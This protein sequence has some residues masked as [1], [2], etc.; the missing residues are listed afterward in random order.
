VAYNSADHIGECIE[1]VLVERHEVTQ[2]VIVVDNA[3]KDDTAARVRA[4]FLEV[5]VAVLEPGQNLGFAAG[6]NYGARH[7][8][9]EFVLLLNPDTVIRN[10]AIDAIVSFARSSP[11]HGLYGGR[12]LRPDGALEP[13]SCWG[14]GGGNEL[15]LVHLTRHAGALWTR[16]KQPHSSR[17][18]RSYSHKLISTYVPHAP[19]GPWDTVAIHWPPPAVECNA[20]VPGGTRWRQVIVTGFRIDEARI[21]VCPIRRIPLHDPTRREDQ[22]AFSRGCAI[23]VYKMSGASDTICGAASIEDIVFEFA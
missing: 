4:R 3:S 12:T 1:S 2:Q 17:R 6:V 19:L 23:A 5:R 15:E 18:S 10:H 11:G 7:V 20:S 22:V 14:G 16:W 8:D 21:F 9:A 13:S